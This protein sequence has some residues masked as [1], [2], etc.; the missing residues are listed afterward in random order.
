V[1]ESKEKPPKPVLNNADL[2]IKQRVFKEMKE[3]QANAKQNYVGTKRERP[4]SSTRHE[5]FQFQKSSSQ[6]SVDTTTKIQV[7]APQ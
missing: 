5:K 7:S 1:K 4:A 3:I 2:R 6:M